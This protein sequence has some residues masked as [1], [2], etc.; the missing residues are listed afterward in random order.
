VAYL[1]IG[2]EPE[3]LRGISRVFQE[4]GFTSSKAAILSSNINS[5]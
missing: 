2:S 5:R 3:K 1:I 4:R